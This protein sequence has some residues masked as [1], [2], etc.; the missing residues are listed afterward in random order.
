M[1]YL[2]TQEFNKRVKEYFC[3]KKNNPAIRKGKK[4]VKQQ[5]LK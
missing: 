5:E 1:H 2:W 4:T 3:L